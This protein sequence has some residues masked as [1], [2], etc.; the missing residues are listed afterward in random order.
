MTQ[1][2][3]VRIWKAVNQWWIPASWCVCSLPTADIGLGGQGIPHPP[4]SAPCQLDCSWIFRA[5]VMHILLPNFGVIGM[6]QETS[7]TQLILWRAFALILMKV[8]VLW[9][10]I[11]IQGKSSTAS[12]IKIWGNS[13]SYT[14]KW[15]L[16]AAAHTETTHCPHCSG[17]KKQLT[18]NGEAACHRR[19]QIN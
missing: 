15:K 16:S 12:T 5:G 11:R 3:E 8:F 9:F 6:S 14:L 13:F 17:A 7:P 1:S 18:L 4:L 19:T 2:W 10:W